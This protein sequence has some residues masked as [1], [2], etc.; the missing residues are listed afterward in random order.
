[1]FRVLLVL[2]LAGGACATAQEGRRVDISSDE[3]KYSTNGKTA[4]FRGNVVV[5][6]DGLR[7][8]AAALLVQSE[9]ENN[10]Y[11]ARAADEGAAGAGVIDLFCDDCAPYVMSGEVG[12]EVNF[13]AAEARLLMS[14]GVSLCVDEGCKRGEMTAARADWARGEQRVHLRGAP[15][16]EAVWR[17]DDAPEPIVA[18]AK[19]V[20]YDLASGEAVLSGE[21]RITRGENTI[22]GKPIHVNLRTG[23]LRAEADADERVQATFGGDGE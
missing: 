7:V 15:M 5:S 21:A 20:R 10:V 17:A 8:K 13:N 6:A 18:Q 14:G 12:E 1:M 11:V 19:E 9:G 16:V 4:E 23:A 2:L 22:R 3:V